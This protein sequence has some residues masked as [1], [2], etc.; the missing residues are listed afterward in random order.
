MDERRGRWA[1][2]G[3][4]AGVALVLAVAG[5]LLPQGVFWHSDEGAKFLQMV[6][7]RWGPD[8]LDT[9]I[10]YPGRA[11][12]PLLQF[13]PFHPKQYHSD[14]AGQIYL[15]W[16]IFLALFTRPL[17]DMLG[18][19]GLYVLPWA[20]AL[21]ACWLTYRLARAVGA[22]P[23]WAWIA[24]PLLGLTTPLGFYSWVFFEH[25]LAAALVAGAA[26]LIVRG[27]PQRDWRQMAGAGALMGAGI[28][29]R[30][31]LYIL[32]LVAGGLFAVR[33]V[34][35]L[36][37]GDAPH[38]APDRAAAW[39]VVRLGGAGL[40]GL[41]I[42]LLPLWGYYAASAGGPLPQ[43]A[44]WYFGGGTP[45][46]A[47]GLALP[48]IRYLAQ[49][50]ARLIPDFLAGPD[51]PTS[52][53]VNPGLVAL[54]LI[55]TVV[56]TAGVLV[57][58]LNRLFAGRVARRV[59]S[60]PVRPANWLLPA[61]LGILALGT[62]PVLLDPNPYSSLHGFVLAAPLVVAAFAARP[63][64]GREAEPVTVLGTFTILY[65]L[66]H[67][68]IISALS[69]I[70]PISRYE[71]GQRYLLPAY[72]LLIALVVPALARLAAT[73]RTPD[74]AAVRTAARLALTAAAVLALIG[75]GFLARGWTALRDGKLEAQSWAAAV[76]AAPG[77]VVL[78]DTWWLP[79]TL[80]PDFYARSWFLAATPTAAATWPAQA[81]A[82]GLGGFTTATTGATLGPALTGATPPATPGP[83]TTRGRVTVQPFTLP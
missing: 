40:A 45:A 64:A 49:A 71:W 12:D 2:V 19:A 36:L 9:S 16:P 63:P 13:V 65:L 79:L 31:E 59:G 41:L 5:A 38:P 11:L 76:A 73:A 69:G 26:L 35:A 3:A 74:G 14:A 52:P 18:W 51:T 77:P 81:R 83:A 57:P 50:R 55:G 15:Q 68:L 22:P 21:A 56:V 7:L 75:A 43:H 37:P 66:L 25:T 72:P 53:V 4:L 60:V 67:V 46:T 24:I 27:L 8:G 70:G 23:G 20:G 44:T 47:G 48:P 30:S 42:V 54:L 29:L 10:R 58:G 6:N 82:A 39:R 62:L 34:A 17:Y 33:A 32:V 28:Y 78:T 61:G 80:A 1:A